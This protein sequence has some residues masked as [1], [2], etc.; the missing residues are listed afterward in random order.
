MMATI[1][2]LKRKLQS[3]VSRDGRRSHP[4]II[5]TGS[6]HEETQQKIKGTQQRLS[7][8]SNNKPFVRRYS[9]CSKMQ[10]EILQSE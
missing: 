9:G 10:V 6:K 1:I 3:R 5:L 4:N 8:A 7:Y 2:Y